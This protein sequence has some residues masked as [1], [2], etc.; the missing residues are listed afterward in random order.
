MKTIN[1]LESIIACE[2]ELLMRD[3]EEYRIAIRRALGRARTITAAV[4]ELEQR[5]TQPI[6]QE[7]GE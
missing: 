6:K 1:E 4:Q 2:R 7:D 3:M 5:S